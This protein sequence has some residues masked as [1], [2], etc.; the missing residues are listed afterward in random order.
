MITFKT[1]GVRTA[2]KFN[3][4]Y[5]IV[6]PAHFFLQW[7]IS[8]DKL[9]LL[10]TQDYRSGGAQMENL[11]GYFDH[12]DVDWASCTPAL[13]APANNEDAADNLSTQWFNKLSTSA[14][15]A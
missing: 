13:S 8:G 5:T 4:K 9:S 6:D 11:L 15:T 10:S 7:D 2:I 3:N 12:A 14:V 1:V